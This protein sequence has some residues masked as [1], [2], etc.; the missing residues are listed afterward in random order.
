MQ[1]RCDRSKI[2]HVLE[3]IHAAY[4]TMLMACTSTSRRGLAS[5]MGLAARSDYFC[6]GDSKSHGT[7][8]FRKAS[9]AKQNTK[10]RIQGALKILCALP[11][12]SY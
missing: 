1:E 11:V 12:Q 4:C 10:R 9:R 2:I 6:A 8:T 5:C 3:D 7:P